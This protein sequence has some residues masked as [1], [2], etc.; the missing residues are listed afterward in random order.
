MQARLNR[1]VDDRTMIIGAVAHDLRTP[2]MRLALRLDQAPEP[3]R[4]ACEGDIRDMQAMIS[5]TLAYVRDVGEPASRRPLD[6]RS[7][8]ETVT[9]DLSDRG[10]PVTLA[11]GL[12]VVI[13]GN[14]AAMKALVTNLV[15][16]ALK[17]AGSAEVSLWREDQ[18]ATIEVCDNGPGI[19][20]EDLERVFE[21]FYRGERS[22]NRDTGGFG[23]GL[24][25][26]RAV[27]RAHG[28]EVTLENRGSGGLCA[29]VTLPA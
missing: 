7:L 14:S 27:A 2:L 20:P 26:V 16:N 19:P 6:L 12:P 5:A 3:L 29:R 23:L 17:Y 1:Y 11:P 28:G 25:S 22:R 4:R 9:D 18:V 21:P 24:A 8:A 10:E 13:E 15:S